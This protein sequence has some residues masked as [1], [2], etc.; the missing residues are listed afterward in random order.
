MMHIRTQL[1]DI[2]VDICRFSTIFISISYEK[3][4]ICCSYE[5]SVDQSKEKKKIPLWKVGKH[6]NPYNNINLNHNN[7]CKGYD[8]PNSNCND[9]GAFKYN[10]FQI[11]FFYHKLATIID[12]PFKFRKITKQ[13]MGTV[14]QL[15]W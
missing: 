6:S 10:T 15:R 3:V 7:N 12:Y 1:K 14:H 13:I 11:Y 5:G 9:S 8:Q 2:N 4:Y